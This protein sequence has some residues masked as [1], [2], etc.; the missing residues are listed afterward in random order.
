MAAVHP[1]GRPGKRITILSIDGG[2]VR[3]VIPATILEF[4]E[5]VL[6]ELD[7]SSVRL[8]DYFDVIAGTSTGGLLTAMLT[9]PEN[10]RPKFSAKE[11]TQHYLDGASTIFPQRIGRLSWVQHVWAMLWGPKYSADGLIKIVDNVVGSSLRVKDT[12]TNVVIPSF[13]VTNEYP[14]FFSTVQAKKDP[15]DNPLLSQVCR[16]TSA[17]PTYLPAVEFTTTNPANGSSRDYNLVDGGTVVNN[18]THVAVVQAV[19]SLVAGDDY[20]ERVYWTGYKDLLVVSLGTG[21]KPVSYDAKKVAKWGLFG[22]VHADD[23]S[24][25]LVELFQNG[26]SDMVDYDLSIVFNSQDCSENY[27][28]IQ[29]DDLNGRAASMDDSSVENM[30]NLVEVAGNLLKKPVSIRNQITGKL[31]P[32]PEFGT[33]AE[34]LRKF[35]KWLS[36]ERKNRT[37]AAQ[38]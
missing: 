23:G 24:V 25:P 7:G 9:V 14:V 4:L 11:V 8:A 15:L 32:R 5:E 10:G 18:P 12:I 20:F 21:K 27:L 2:G 28:R 35:A 30:K 26:S 17:A 33:N 1:K 34:A 3:G 16:G 19:K 36:H 31:E 22:W 13:D 6:Q 37:Q 29:T 38:Q